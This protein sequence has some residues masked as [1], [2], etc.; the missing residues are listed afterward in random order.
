MVT[1]QFSTLDT[2]DVT[3]Y[4]RAKLE[5]EIDDDIIE[6]YFHTVEIVKGNIT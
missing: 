6:T 3:D 4:G 5:L 2:Q 1:V